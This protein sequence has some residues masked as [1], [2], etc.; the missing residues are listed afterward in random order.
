MSAISSLVSW[1]RQRRL[2]PLNRLGQLKRLLALVPLANLPSALNL[3]DRPAPIPLNR[4][5]KAS[6]HSCRQLE[7]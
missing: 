4:G 7:K 1:E 3:H 6:A 2:A 5:T